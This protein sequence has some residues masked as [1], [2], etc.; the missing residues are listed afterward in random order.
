MEKKTFSRIGLILAVLALWF[1]GAQI[2]MQWL[3]YYRVM[4]YYRQGFL[5][6]V[7]PLLLYGVGALILWLGMRP[8]ARQP[9]QPQ[10]KM[11]FGQ[12]L[13]FFC[14]GRGVSMVLSIV[15]TLVFLLVLLLV[16]GM[17][18]VGHYL[19]GLNP[20]MTLDL[21]PDMLY[22]LFQVCILAPV[23][24][25]LMFRKFL[26]E[27]LRPFGDK[28]AILYSG[29]AFGLLH[30]DF[31]QFFYAAALGLFLGYIMVRTNNLWYCIGLHFVINVS[32]S[33]LLPLLDEIYV[34]S[35]ALL[36][37]VG[38]TLLLLALSVLGL[39]LFFIYVRRIKLFPSPYQFSRPINTRLALFGG[40]GWV[41]GVLCVATPVILIAL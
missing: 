3:A 30:M 4:W 39:V 35:A 6:F 5:R 33:V 8:L 12:F 13:G 29:I 40:W 16:R 11:G 7:F 21:G 14:A 37:A 20:L 31:R 18:G 19:T 2:L 22:S 25:E 1:G 24:E 9:K 32:S 10:R 41:Y 34:S 27:P 26:L 17:D 28:M 23:V 38:W 36:L 15:G